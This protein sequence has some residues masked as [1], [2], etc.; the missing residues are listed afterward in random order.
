MA[1][2]AVMAV[3]AVLSGCGGWAT[4]R[5]ARPATTSSGTTRPA[6]KSTRSPPGACTA[7]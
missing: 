3:A 4:R 1:V 2:V 7:V 6:G 5:T